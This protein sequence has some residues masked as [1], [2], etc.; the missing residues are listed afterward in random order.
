[1]Y[2]GLGKLTCDTEFFL[3]NANIGKGGCFAEMKV[4]KQNIFLEIG[5]RGFS[6]NFTD[7]RQFL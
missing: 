7:T 5:V 1:M 3:I 4:K 6:E 2:W